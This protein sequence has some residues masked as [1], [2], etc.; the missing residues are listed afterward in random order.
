MRFLHNLNESNFRYYI[1]IRKDYFVLETVS[2][3]N[4]ILTF[5]ILLINYY[6]LDENK[7]ILYQILIEKDK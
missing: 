6:A 7:K 2:Y 1:K 4:K 3:L 5:N